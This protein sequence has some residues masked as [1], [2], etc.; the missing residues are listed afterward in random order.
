[1]RDGASF[2]I[3]RL[4]TGGEEELRRAAMM[5]WISFECA[6]MKYSRE[7]DGV[8]WIWVLASFIGGRLARLGGE[9]QKTPWLFAFVRRVEE[10]HYLA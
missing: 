2:Q 4:R 8:V 5:E 6:P 1:M 10:G 3:S 7:E 9:M